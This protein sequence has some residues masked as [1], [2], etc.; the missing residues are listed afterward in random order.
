VT[1]GQ[2]PE[3]FED[4]GCGCLAGSDNQGTSGAARTPVVRGILEKDGAT[5]TPRSKREGCRV[6]FREGRTTSIPTQIRSRRYS[7]TGDLK[8]GR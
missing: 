8:R 4:G 3:P 5:W 1:D 2:R 6:A 7:D